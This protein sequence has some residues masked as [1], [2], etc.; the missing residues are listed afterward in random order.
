MTLIVLKLED[1]LD[2]EIN[3]RTHIER[4][5]SQVLDKLMGL[6]ESIDDLEDEFRALE[7]RACDPNMDLDSTIRLARVRRLFVL[8]ALTDRSFEDNLLK[9]R[10]KYFN[11]IC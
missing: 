2:A 11:L 5:T 8:R 7:R 3:K 6:R 10:N 1:D 4:R 9:I